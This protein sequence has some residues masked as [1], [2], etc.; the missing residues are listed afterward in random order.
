MLL[1]RLVPTVATVVPGIIGAG[2]FRDIADAL[3]Q[4]PGIAGPHYTI[5][6]GG[7]KQKIKYSCHAFIISV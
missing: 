1:A 4:Y 2:C 7:G 6:A 3:L 5:I